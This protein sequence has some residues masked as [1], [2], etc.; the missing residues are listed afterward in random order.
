MTVLDTIFH[1]RLIDKKEL[2][3]LVCYS[4]S[5]IRRLEERGLFPRRIQLG[6]GRVAWLYAEVMQWIENKADGRGADA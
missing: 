4:P 5:Q 6:P 2:R 1:N 3:K